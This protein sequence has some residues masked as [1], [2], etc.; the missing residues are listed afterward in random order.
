MTDTKNVD[1]LR[2]IMLETAQIQF[3]TLNAGIVFWSQWVENAS[4][5]AQGISN[6]LL[7]AGKEGSDTDKILG[8]ITDLTREYLRKT[9][10]LPNAAVARFNADVK[11]AGGPK[12]TRTRTRSARVKT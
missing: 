1:D 4:K 8:T 10:E 9:T 5:T 2:Q 3:A 11:P 12:G 6:Q 7:L